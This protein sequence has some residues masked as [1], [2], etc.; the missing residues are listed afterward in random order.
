MYGRS[1]A[2]KGGSHA[3]PGYHIQGWKL[4]YT[5]PCGQREDG[6]TIKSL[7]SDMLVLVAS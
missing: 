6:G 5:D 7:G 2:G 3:S 1:L 4:A